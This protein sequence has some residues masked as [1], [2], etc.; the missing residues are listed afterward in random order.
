MPLEIFFT[1]V[2]LALLCFREYLNN[3]RWGFPL[4]ANFH[5]ILILLIDIYEY[6]NGLIVMAFGNS[7]EFGL[8][9]SNFVHLFNTN[10]NQLSNQSIATMG[11]QSYPDQRMSAAC[12]LGILATLLLL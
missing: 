2:D 10:T 8:Y 1:L 9:D 12:A 4:M 3:S 11:G 6:S 5:F 7:Y